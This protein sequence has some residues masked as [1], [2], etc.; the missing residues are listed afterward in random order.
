M[1]FKA[2]IRDIKSNIRENKT[3]FA[4]Y[5]ILRVIVIV[6]LAFSLFRQDFQSA[7][8]CALCLILFL[9]PPLLEKTLKIELPSLLEILIL[10]FI[11]ASQILGDIGYF[12]VRVP[13]WD[14]ILH[15]VNGFLCA[16]IGFAL[17]D[18]LNSNKQIKFD[19]SPIYVSIVAICFSMTIGILWEFLEFFSDM[20]LRTDMQKDTILNSISSVILDPT[21]SNKTIR[22]DDI[23]NIS[24]NGELL[25]VGGYIDIGLIDTMKDL[26]VNF[27]GAIVFSVLGYFY[28][29]NRRKGGFAENFIPKKRS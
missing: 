11:F 25:G 9:I 26:I 3:T 4:I 28:L 5:I 1:K 13:H 15:T 18:I 12:Y 8:I 16:A 7:F 2:F 14:T 6:A 27:I 22:I 19:L 23:K 24:I 17:V 21:N 29:K 10:L 20:L